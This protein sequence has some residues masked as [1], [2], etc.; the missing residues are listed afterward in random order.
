MNTDIKKDQHF[1]HFVTAS[2]FGLLAILLVVLI[3]KAGKNPREI[4]LFDFFML[5]LATF[6]VTR[7]LVHDL[8]LDFIRDFFA[9][10]NHG[11]GLSMIC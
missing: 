1:W 7:L 8:V 6:R 4:P 2:V 10:S 9:S 11:L 5:A 3:S